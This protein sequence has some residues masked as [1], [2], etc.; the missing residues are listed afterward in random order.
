LAK[1]KNRKLHWKAS[2]SASVVGYKVYWAE[3]GKVT[4]ASQSADLGNV[5]EVLLPDGVAGFSPGQ[6]PV[7]FG[8]TA[9]DEQG[10]ESDMVTL[11]AGDQFIAPPA[12]QGLQLEAL[13]ECSTAASQPESEA[14]LQPVQL[15]EKELYGLE[16]QNMQ[17]EDDSLAMDAQDQKPLNY[18]GRFD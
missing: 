1:F 6:G 14:P 18:Y 12:P 8:I 9:V 11:A 2:P 15:P 4:Y 17:A 3:G 10:N 5:T 7:E 13:G 16:E